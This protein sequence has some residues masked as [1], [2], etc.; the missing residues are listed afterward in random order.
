MKAQDD[1]MPGQDTGI[2]AF[3]IAD[4]HGY[5]AFTQDRGD[6]A[7]AR[8]ATKFGELTQASVE[9]AGGALI[10]LRGD[11]ALVV[12]DS[13]RQAVR[14]AIAL[15]ARFIGETVADP[16]LPLSVGIGLDAGEAVPVDG[17]FRGGA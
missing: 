9:T 3:L 1:P 7:A 10:E 17:G 5:T 8:L 13:A 15:Q 14:A 4:V 12:F 16:T 2:K 11:E 6:E